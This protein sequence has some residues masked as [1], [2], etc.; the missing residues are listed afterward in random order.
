M[1]ERQRHDA[2]WRL[3]LV[4]LLLSP[5]SVYG[6]LQGRVRYDFDTLHFLGFLFGGIAL[7]LL[8]D[9]LLNVASGRKSALRFG[10]VR[11]SV[12]CEGREE[13]TVSWALQGLQQRLRKH[14]F[15]DET[16]DG[17]DGAKIVTFRR[18]KD[19]EVHSFL[20]HAF[21]GKAT[22]APSGTGTHV[23]L[24]LTLKDT[25]LI[26]S[27][28]NEHL[29]QFGDYLTGEA[30]QFTYSSVPFSVYHGV[31]LGFVT[32]ALSALH[33]VAPGV[34]GLWIG[35]AAY[36]GFITLFFVLIQMFRDREHLFGFRLVGAGLFL[37]LLP[38]FGLL[39]RA[40]VG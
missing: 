6:L 10:T 33:A 28:E 18:L 12:T 31:A 34:S 37:C 22:L 14:K 21:E 7:P 2:Y 16:A 19:A 40:V 35:S 3:C 38:V 32:A 1:T 17:P 5:L 8:L 24:D 23:S 15:M 39:A 11:P 25:I 26:D 29:R 30:A 4:F 9:V 36:A 27:G 20:N 13:G